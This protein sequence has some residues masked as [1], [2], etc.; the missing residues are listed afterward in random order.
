[1]CPSTISSGR[2][3][4]GSARYFFAAGMCPFTILPQKISWSVDESGKY[5][6]L[7]TRYD[8]ISTGGVDIIRDHE[9]ETTLRGVDVVQ[10]LGNQG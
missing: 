1:M 10:L 7:R 5:D 2:S 4:L 8:K 9:S 6:A 3:K